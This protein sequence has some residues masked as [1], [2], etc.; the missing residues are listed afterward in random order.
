MRYVAWAAV[1][2]WLTLGGSLQAE[3]ILWVNAQRVSFRDVVPQS[4]GS[5]ASLDLGSAPPLGSSRLF[6]KDD[7]RTF[8]LIAH[9][10]I[11]G[12]AIPDSVRVMRVTRRLSEHD[13]DALVRPALSALLPEGAILKYLGLP[14]TLLSVPNVRVGEI[15]MP[16]LPKRA[17]IARITPVVELVAGGM[18]VTRLP[19]SVD[20][21]LDERVA[22]FAL[23]RGAVLN[24][25]IETGTTR[26]S[27]TAALMT[28]GDVGD[29]VACQVTKTRKVLRARIVSSREA[30]VVQQ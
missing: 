20:L 8:A 29:V 14:K 11:D 2:F 18:L 23:D 10:N 24:L 7:L 21:Q 30:T 28:P 6:S 22:R 25:V 5:L 27:A 17:G 19:V 12:I 3:T 26:I 1:P 13:L 15:Q 16:R 4:S 9:E